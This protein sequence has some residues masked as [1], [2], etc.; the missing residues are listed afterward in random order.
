M[1][2]GHFFSVI[3]TTYNRRK[4]LRSCIDS[5]L[6]Q[7]YPAEKY[8]IILVDD[9]SRDGSGEMVR[10]VFGGRVRYLYQDNSGWA[11]ARNLGLT[12]SRG[13]IVIFIDDDCRVAPD[14][15]TL[16]EAAYLAHPEVGGVAGRVDAGP[17]MNLAGKIRFRGHVAIFN[18]LNAPLGTRYESPG[19]VNF[20][21]GAN[22]SYRREVLGEAPFDARL[23]Y[24]EDHD[25]D[26]RLKEQGVLIF[27]D[28][29][30]VVWHHY[31]LSAWGR[32]RADFYYARS[33]VLFR[34]LHPDFSTPQNVRPAGWRSPFRLF[35]DFPEEPLK[36]K[37]SYLIVQAL[38]RAARA[39]GTFQGRRELK[40]FCPGKANMI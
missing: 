4:L 18:E 22:R 15:L 32:I 28:P 37:L 24:F 38:C 2:E 11:A 17:E 26:L 7:D 33:E 40:R 9:G 6:S 29:R 25:L 30:V 34:A 36:S 39:F 31:R 27:Y 3:V 21:Y 10:S 14:W 35:R 1:R 13:E 12:Q 20:C 16:Y 5:L 8:E 23:W 19:Y